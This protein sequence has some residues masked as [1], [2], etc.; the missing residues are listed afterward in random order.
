MVSRAHAGPYVGRLA[1]R[2]VGADREYSD[3]A[4]AVV[5]HEHEL[6]GRVHAE[7]RRRR[8]A[9]S[10]R[11]QSLQ[12]HV[13]AVDGVGNYGTVLRALEIVDFA[14][15]VQVSLRRIESQP[16]RIANSVDD[17]KLRQG[18]RDWVDSKQINAAAVRGIGP[19][20]GK[21]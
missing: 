5:G 2:T 10:H 15:C 17:L 18:G 20:I 14:D 12:L 3:I 16:G 8:A 6:S 4:A 9:R 7:V 19:H 11:S 21:V 1:Q 13:C